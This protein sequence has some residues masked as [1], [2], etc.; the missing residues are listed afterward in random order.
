MDDGPAKRLPSDSGRLIRLEAS[1]KDATMNVK[2]AALALAASLLMIGPVASQPY[3]PGMMG[4]YGGGWGMGPGMMGGYGGGWGMGPGMM[5]GYGPGG[6]MGPGMMG[7]YGGDPYAGLDLTAD[8]RKKIADT[9]EQAGKAMWQLMGTMHEQGYRMHDLVGP[10]TLDEQAA[11]KAFEAMAATHKAMFDLQLD[12]RRKVDAILT[13][14][15][16]DR[17]RKSWGNR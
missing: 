2:R 14:E 16:R 10:G 3:G 9:R 17:L 4:G 5:G 7:G 15:Q 13:Q 8:Q 11:R 6:G 12:A 1:R